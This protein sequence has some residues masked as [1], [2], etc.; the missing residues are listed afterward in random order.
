MKFWW[1]HDE[2]IIATLLAWL[3]TGEARYARWH[4][5]VHAWAHRHFA[6]PRHGEWFGYLDRR[7][8]VALSLK[9]GKWK[10]FFHIPRA[11]LECSRWLAEM[12]A[13]CPEGGG[14]LPPFPVPGQARGGKR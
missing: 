9:G 14:Y 5:Q 6:D 7:G 8:E 10:G 3:A 13:A 11:L 2:A 12:A 1:P 4:E